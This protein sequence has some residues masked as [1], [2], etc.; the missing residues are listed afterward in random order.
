M[1]HEIATAVA[2][3]FVQQSTAKK[4]NDLVLMKLLYIS[5]RRAL[6]QLGTPIICDEYFSMKNS[7]VLS[8]VLSLMQGAQNQFWSDHLIFV[9][10]DGQTSN[11]IVLRHPLDPAKYLS[12]AE[13]DL[14]QGVWSEFGH[15]GKWQLVDLTHNFPEWDSTLTDATGGSRRSPISVE[16]ILHKG[17]SMGAQEASQRAKDLQYYN[18][19]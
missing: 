1:N 4:L 16:D 9:P 6:I 2:C 13:L 17:F 8:G 15:R 18:S 3:F 14:L 12:E 5:E 19:L 7:P 11:H 10:H